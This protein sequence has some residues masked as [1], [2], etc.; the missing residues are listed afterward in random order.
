MNH[1]LII[2]EGIPGSGKTTI[3]KK[4]AAWLNQHNLKATCYNESDFHPADLSW[5]AVLTA[6]EYE[7]LLNKWSAYTEQIQAQAWQEADQILVTYSNVEVSCKEDETL[8]DDFAPYEVYDGNWSLADFTAIHLERWQRFANQAQQEDHIAVFECAWLQNHVN[9]LMMFHNKSQE[10]M[11]HHLQRL[12]DIVAALDPLVIYLQPEDVTDS[13]AKVSAARVNKQGEP[14]WRD[15][16]IDVVC[17]S[18]FGKAHQ[19][20]GMAGMTEYFRIRNQVE[21]Q[22]LKQLPASAHIFTRSGDDWQALWQQVENLLTK[23]YTS[24]V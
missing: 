9:E 2:V 20:Q 23:I 10:E 3:A 11:L 21:L 12:W 13:I 8:Y 14:V 16:V 15:R 24:Q 5:I 7:N 19:L 1:R 22:M 18:P 17:Q 4:V 6:D